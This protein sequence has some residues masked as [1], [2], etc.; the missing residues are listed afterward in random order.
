[1]GI[2]KLDKNFAIKA[3]V[4]KED[5]VWHSLTEE[6]FDIYGLYNPKN[7][8]ELR[9]MPRDIA[10]K[11]SDPVAVL[12]RNTAGGR[13]RFRTDSPY[14]AIRIYYE[15]LE[16]MPHMPRSGSSGID[17]YCY[18]NGEYRFL[19]NAMPA[20]YDKNGYER[21]VYQKNQ[22]MSD[23]LIH[24]PLYNDVLKLEIGLQ[25]GCKLENG[26]KYR[27]VAPVVY[28]GS[29]ITQGGCAS[30]PANAYENMISMMLDVDHINLG[31]SGNAK[32]EPAMADYIGGLN[33]SVFVLDYD[34]NAPNV[35]HLE[36]TH[37]AFYQRF[38]SHKPD[39][40]VI[41]VSRPD[42]DSLELSPEARKE[43]IK[44]TYER[45][46]AQ[47]D[48]NVFFI[49]GATLFGTDF[50]G[51]CSVDGCHPNDLGFYR[52]AKIIGEAVKTYIGEKK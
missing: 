51:E 15:V 22:G 9:R 43:V 32:G 3:N 2:E 48:R 50:R 47:G 6:C 20:A 17:L 40:P 27:D 37:Y 52:M 18:E 5:I 16:N 24:L 31:F 23:F 1:M 33:M 34:H 13:V 49:D 7:G 46:L 29:S 39:T 21:L 26:A 4:D 36:N 38:R 11:V 30:R 44:R 42:T 12:C 8:E 10:E 41:M 35:A 19:K 28:Y 14:I 25:V 45:A